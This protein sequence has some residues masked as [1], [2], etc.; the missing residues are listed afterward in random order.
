MNQWIRGK[1]EERR[2]LNLGGKAECSLEA[3]ERILVMTPGGGGYG[4]EE[5]PSKKK[6]KV[7]DD[8]GGRAKKKAKKT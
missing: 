5:E 6:E 4:V 3:G 1:G 8:E 7:G 2:V